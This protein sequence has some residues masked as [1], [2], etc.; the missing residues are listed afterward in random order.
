MDITQF[1]K[2]NKYLIFYSNLQTDRHN[3]VYGSKGTLN[4]IYLDESN[5]QDTFPKSYTKNAAFSQDGK[6]LVFLSDDSKKVH[7]WNLLDKKIE[8]VYSC[9]SGIEQ[10]ALSKDNRWLFIFTNVLKVIDLSLVLQEQRSYYNK[11][12]KFTTEER[13]HYGIEE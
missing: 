3:Y 6:L 2:N 11:I 13:I 1:S 5:K 12:L 7:I 9:E 8:N 10:F 4:L